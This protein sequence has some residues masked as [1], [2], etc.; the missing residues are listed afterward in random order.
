MRF[1]WA[2]SP[3]SSSPVDGAWQESVC[4]ANTCSVGSAAPGAATPDVERLTITLSES[5]MLAVE[6]FA[7]M[8]TGSECTRMSLVPA[9]SST[10][11]PSAPYVAMLTFWC[12]SSSPLCVKSSSR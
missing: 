3:C 5:E 8:V 9:P 6:W 2:D 1:A 4:P 7:E 11:W 10:M 12:S